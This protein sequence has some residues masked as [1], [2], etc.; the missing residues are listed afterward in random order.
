MMA[1]RWWHA[2]PQ[3][4]TGLISFEAEADGDWSNQFGVLVRRNPNSTA[5]QA[6]SVGAMEARKVFESSR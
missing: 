6:S 1:G 2:M 3:Y 4:L 5:K